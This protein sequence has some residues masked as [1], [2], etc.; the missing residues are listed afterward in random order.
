[1]LTRFWRR[2]S[3]GCPGVQLPLEFDRVGIPYA[4]RALDLLDDGAVE[5]IFDLFQGLRPCLRHKQHTN[6]NREQSGEAEQEVG[7]KGR[8]R[9]ENRRAERHYPVYDLESVSYCSNNA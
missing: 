6:H 8:P 5:G 7:S 2:L 9:Q 4:R 3:N 1:M